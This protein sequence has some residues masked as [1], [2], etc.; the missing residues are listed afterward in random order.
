MALL[1][2]MVLVFLVS[3]GGAD[4]S[5]N[6]GN[7]VE[8]TESVRFAEFTREIFTRDVSG[9]GITLHFY[10]SDPAAFDIAADSQLGLGDHTMEGIE[11]YEK[12]VREDLDRLNGFDYDK[13][14]AEQQLTYDVYKNRLETE[15]LSEGMGLFVSYVTLNDGILTAYPQL[16][17]DYR[18]QSSED[19]DSYLLLLAD[20]PRVFDEALRQEQARSEAGLF[21]SEVILD[22]VLNA[23]KSILEDPESSFMLTSFEE[24]LDQ[25]KDLDEAKRQEYIERNRNI[26][27]NEVVPAGIS[28]L[29]GL[30][31]MRG[32][33]TAAQGLW[34]YRDG[35]EYYS[36]LLKYTS[37]ID[38]SVEEITSTLEKALMETLTEMV[39]VLYEAPEAM[40]EA[41]SFGS[42]TLPYQSPEEIM[43]FLR[44]KSSGEF[45][46]LEDVSYQIRE[47]PESLQASTA[48]AY[49]LTPPLDQ[50]QDNFIYINGYEDY[51][52]Q[53]EGE[54]LVETLA[55]EGYPGHLFQRNYFSQSDPDPLR[56]L[57]SV[58]GYTEGWANYVDA[59]CYRW[60]GYSEAASR[61]LVCNDIASSI[62]SA[63][64]DIGVHY[65]GWNVEDVSDYLEEWGFE[66]S[67]AQAVFENVLA[68]PG[69]G[70]PYILGEL[71]FNR[72][73][74]EAETRLG[75]R[76]DPVE[77]HQVV[78]DCGPVPL[79]I[80][81]AQVEAY[82]AGAESGVPSLPDA[83]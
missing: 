68:D 48:P 38:S 2:A 20:L 10:L 64:I 43:E 3:C 71:E 33:C 23:G 27:L 17:A 72:L 61:I 83:A 18:I 29:D 63:R 47:V 69:N 77:F 26:W 12:Q 6:S 60:L 57:I 34:Q 21:M 76:F 54:S 44:E 55:H 16:L 50:P 24:R 15:L 35:R 59:N 8:K 70:I 39:S 53:T 80:L 56:Y 42:G 4:Q 13:L 49:Y 73:R 52:S 65:D 75:D 78:L 28:L 31:A 1:T 62:V 37:G 14:T 7:P 74:Q 41:Y 67:V 40:D 79:D 25:L 5:Q 58:L 66:P 51:K 22:Q 32:S 30:E 46:S 19:V 11:E 81:A 82:L 45:P 36:Y 9:D